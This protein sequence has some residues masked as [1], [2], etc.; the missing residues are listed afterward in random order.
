MGSLFNQLHANKQIL[1]K[2]KQ[3]VG[4]IIKKDL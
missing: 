1:F 3:S 4:L 2:L